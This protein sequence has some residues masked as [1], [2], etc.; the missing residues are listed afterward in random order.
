MTVSIFKLEENNYNSNNFK[1]SQTKFSNFWRSI[2]NW[3]GFNIYYYYFFLLEQVLLLVC[4][5]LQWSTNF[6]SNFKC[7][8]SKFSDYYGSNKNWNFNLVNLFL[9]LDKVLA[10][11]FK[12][13]CQFS[14]R[15]W[16]QKISNNH[17]SYNTKFSNFHW[18]NKYTNFNSF[19]LKFIII[20]G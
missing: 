15:R 12:K 10:K 16:F 4:Q 18:S 19:K 7:F 9:F 14:L 13:K 2:P 6:Y 5:N 20:N 3:L 8:W 17:K 11:V 1:W